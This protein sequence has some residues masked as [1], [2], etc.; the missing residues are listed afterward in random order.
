MKFI[1][2][3]REFESGFENDHAAYTAL[4]RAVTDKKTRGDFAPSLCQSYVKYGSWTERQRPWAHKLAMEATQ[5]P[6]ERKPAPKF[7]GYGKI[8]DHL[9]ECRERRQAGGKGLLYPT[10]HLT[11]GETTVVLKLCGLK[12]KRKG[13]VSV[14]SSHRYG[15]GKFYGYISPDGEYEPWTGTPQG[16]FEIL[17]CLK[18]N[19]AE[20]ISELGKESGRCCYCLAELTQV[21][22]KIAGCG[23]TCADNWN[24]PYPSAK[25]TRAV[26]A[27]K[28]ELLDGSTDRERWEKSV[29]PDS[30]TEQEEL[31]AAT[32]GIHGS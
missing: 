4:Q 19:P 15:E 2:K 17:D 9:R 18:P 8:V 28:P 24:M 26:L 13:S 7:P 12:S 30:A 14:A 5:G 27:V 22:S 11:V 32:Y 1:L 10:V 21:Q 16:V 20:G 25:E 23:K 31:L 3:G 6:Q 29:D